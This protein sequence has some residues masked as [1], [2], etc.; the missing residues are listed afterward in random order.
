MVTMFDFIRR[1]IRFIFLYFRSIVQF[2]VL[3]DTVVRI[4][5]AIADNDK[6]AV[7]RLTYE[8]FDKFDVIPDKCIIPGQNYTLLD[9]AARFAS[10][11]MF[12]MM[13]ELGYSHQVDECPTDI[14]RAQKY[15][16][17]RR[18]CLQ[19]ELMALKLRWCYN[20]N[21]YVCDMVFHY[22][23]DIICPVRFDNFLKDL[24]ENDVDLEDLRGAMY[25]PSRYA[26]MYKARFT[27]EEREKTKRGQPVTDKKSEDP[28]KNSRELLRKMYD[29][30]MGYDFLV[31]DLPNT[32]TLGEQSG[33]IP[34]VSA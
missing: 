31:T 20:M 17:T 30:C 8:Y 7:R 18:K 32:T 2:Y 29:D 27:I 13:V 1:S 10:Q 12:D 5:G 33:C 15:L 34:P 3:D 11:S 6:N 24:V 23:G 22:D 14:I 16:I 26:E 25:L 4:Y 28:F 9:A 19:P 21:K